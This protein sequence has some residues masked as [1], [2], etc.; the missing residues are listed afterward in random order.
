MLRIL[1]NT[2]LSATICVICMAGQAAHAQAV[3]VKA[4]QEGQ[5][6][7]FAE[8]GVCYLLTAAHVTQGAR[9]AQVLTQSGGE[10][11]ATM[12]APFWQGFDL[13][14]GQVRRLAQGD[15][16]ASFED[17]VQGAAQPLSGARVVLPVVGPGGIDNLDLAVSRSDYLE[18]TGQ[19]LAADA[20]GKKGMSGG[21]ALAGAVPV[22]M[23]RATAADGS[24]QFVQMA[25]I[26][27]NVRR[28]L[29]RSSFSAPADVPVAQ[30]SAQGIPFQIVSATPPAIDSA[31]VIEAMME[32]AGP[33]AYAAGQDAVIVL[34][35][36]VEGQKIISRLRIESI[37]TDGYSQ[38]LQV[39]V[40]VT[41]QEGQ[42]GTRYWRIDPFPPDGMYDTGPVARRFAALVT[43]TLIG[44]RGDTPVRIDRIVLD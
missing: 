30:A 31:H 29:D 36:M 39:R 21:F 4:A 22:G 3:Q 28:W 42:A 23:A 10:G 32:G 25:E 37:P 17:L 24:V 11:S 19:F 16:T 43:L 12:V 5:G 13:D 6:F 7:L 9:R 20:A 34:K 15:C 8:E 27:M 38:P 35:N 18:F 33:F 40:D 2:V 14:V 41:P 26:A 44:A 1:E